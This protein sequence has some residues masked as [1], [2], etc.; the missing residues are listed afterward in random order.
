MLG[1]T[2]LIDLTQ[3]WTEKYPDLIRCFKSVLV[4]KY[5]TKKTKHRTTVQSK[6]DKTSILNP[7]FTVKLFFKCA[8]FFV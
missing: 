7:I 4:S 5:W 1:W 6:A 2:V 8:V 3:G